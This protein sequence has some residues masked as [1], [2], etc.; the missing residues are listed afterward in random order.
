MVCGS[1]GAADRRKLHAFFWC[2]HDDIYDA[3]DASPIAVGV[4]LLKALHA[5]DPDT[6]FTPTR[7]AA[8]TASCD[9]AVS[10]G[11]KM[12]VSAAAKAR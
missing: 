7:L 12:H 10:G 8:A 11:L 2:D 9:A 1:L 4:L 5:F 3:Y 6:A